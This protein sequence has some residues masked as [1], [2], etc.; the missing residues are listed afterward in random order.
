M[1]QGLIESGTIAWIA[2]GILAVELIALTLYFRATGR[3][4]SPRAAIPS[5]LA[6]AGL[7]G[8]LAAAL[9]SAGWPWIAVGVTI[10]LVA[11]V[12]DLAVRWR[13]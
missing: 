1:L 5:L 7:W 13:H 4:L 10:A 6:G 3:G 11:H 12:A 9:T 8:A 2:L